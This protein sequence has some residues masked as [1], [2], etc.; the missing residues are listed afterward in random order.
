MKLQKNGQFPDEVSVKLTPHSTI[1]TVA[2]GVSSSTVNEAWIAVVTSDRVIAVVRDGDG[3]D[4][5]ELTQVAAMR[6][7]YSRCVLLWMKAVG[8]REKAFER[9]DYYIRHHQD[10]KVKNKAKLSKHNCNLF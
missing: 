1:P 7:N 9:I 6:E 5:H 4:W 3:E 10:A 8:S 2:S